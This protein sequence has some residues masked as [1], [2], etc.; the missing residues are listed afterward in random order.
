MTGWDWLAVIAAAIGLLLAVVYAAQG[1]LADAYR[2]GYEKGAEEGFQKGIFE[3]MR[4]VRTHGAQTAARTVRKPG[5]KAE[6]DEGEASS[7]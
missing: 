2:K 4:T 7:A 1:L 5:P 6:G 3:A